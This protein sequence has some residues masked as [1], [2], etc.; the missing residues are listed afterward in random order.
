M[1]ACYCDHDRL[2][3][4]CQ[5]LPL[6]LFTNYGGEV[7]SETG[8]PVYGILGKLNTCYYLF[9]KTLFLK[10]LYVGVILYVADWAMHEFINNFP[11]YGVLG[12]SVAGYGH[13]R[14]LSGHK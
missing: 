12:N 2:Q 6:P 4:I 1:P 10:T 13:F 3:L 7:L 5:E 8:L 11:V 14:K 9:L